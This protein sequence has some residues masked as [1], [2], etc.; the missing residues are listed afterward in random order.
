MKSKFLILEDTITSANTSGNGVKWQDGDTYEIIDGTV[1]CYDPDGAV[2]ADAP[3]DD[4]TLEWL[5]GGDP[6]AT[7][8][9]AR[10]PLMALKTLLESPKFRPYEL[11]G[12]KELSLK[13]KHTQ[14]TG[15]TTN[16][17]FPIKVR[18]MLHL[19]KKG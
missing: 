5:I 15:G 8:A 11:P 4:I 2:L 1:S 9:E 6:V 12:M 17:T 18:L 19:V 14:V 7:T 3:H 13:A 16:N 10:I